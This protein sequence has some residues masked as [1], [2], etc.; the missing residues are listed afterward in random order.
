MLFQAN[1]QQLQLLVDQHEQIIM[2][3]DEQSTCDLLKKKYQCMSL[4]ELTQLV[5]FIRADRLADGDR[6]LTSLLVYLSDHRTASTIQLK[7]LPGLFNAIL[8]QYIGRHRFCSFIEHI[9]IV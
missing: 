8:E 4:H 5:Y 1:K 3:T 9:V 6:H 7:T 2:N